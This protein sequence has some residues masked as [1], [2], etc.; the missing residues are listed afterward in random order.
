LAFNVP[1]ILNSW[2]HWKK[3]MAVAKG[4]HQLLAKT[5][6]DQSR[7]CCRIIHIEGDTIVISCEALPVL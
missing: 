2:H 5:P 4:C 7:R 6:K 1:Y 3:I